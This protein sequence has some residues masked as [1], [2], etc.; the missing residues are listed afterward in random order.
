MD[1]SGLMGRKS[2]DDILESG[3]GEQQLSKTLGALSITAMGI[4]AIIGAGIFVLTGTAAAQYAGPGIM[5]SFVLG[6]IACAFVGLC[7]SEMAALIPV[8]GSSYTYTYATLGE[9]FAWLIGWDLILEYAMGA[10][11]VAVGWSGYVTSLLKDVGIVIPARFAHAPGT[12]IDGGGTALFNLP[13]VVIVALITI[14]LMRGTKESARFNNIMVAVK[15]TVVVAFIALGWGHVDIAHWSPLIP[16]NEGTFGQY[17]YSGILRGAGVVFFAFI[18]FD[19]VS[20]AAQEARKPQKDMP[21]G[22]LGSLAVCTIL[23]VLVA[24]VLTGLVPYKELNV[25]DPIAKGVDAIGIGWFALLI[26]LGALTG[27]TTV[28]LVLLYGQSRIFFTMANDGLLPKLFAHVHPTYQT[29]YRSQALIGAA[30][31]LVAALVPIH[32][33]GEMVSIGTLAAFI[34]VCGSVIYLRRTDRHMKRPFRAPAVPVVPIL[35]ILFCLLLMVGLPLDTW[36]R[37]VIWMA[38]GLVIYF[39]YGRRHSVLRR[40]EGN[41]VTP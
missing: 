35:G 19:A 2:V 38:I 16:P 32:I 3:E 39:F 6:G 28:I 8:A 25:P 36:L 11:T 33:L 9:F 13:A 21:I 40:K 4:G 15:L 27:L 5:L 31:A 34:L 30:V 37:L 12:A 18:G 26:K 7:Y 14:L 22:I 17:G 10:A 24:A 20:T 1:S 29:P 23:Y 41:A